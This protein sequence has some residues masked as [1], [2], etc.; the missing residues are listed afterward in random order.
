MKTKKRNIALYTLATLAILFAVYS[1]FQG[2]KL[3]KNLKEAQEKNTLLSNSFA[4]KNKL[5][6]I[7][8]ILIKGRYESALNA[9]QEEFNAVV[10]DDDK[11]YVKFRIE[12]AQQFIALTKGARRKDSL[13]DSLDL[14]ERNGKNEMLTSY[15]I[16]KYDSLT[17]ALEKAKVQLNRVK[18]QVQKKSYGEYLT[19]RNTKK[20]QLHY[21]GQVSEGKASGF[22]IA[23]FDTGSRYEGE[24]KD[25]LRHGE[26]AFYW[27]DGECYQG[28]YQ[29]DLRNGYGTYFWPNGEK[30]VG[31]WKNDQRDGEGVFYGKDEN[32]I[33][34]GV[35]KKD[36]LVDEYKDKKRK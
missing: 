5:F 17:F 21:I 25:N 36:K 31:N 13:A 34:K 29:N 7:D 16:R 24:W 18:K 15:N 10:N 19:F 33:T 14:L 32:I 8:S 23:L 11:T 9:Y 27:P 28:E 22:G 2:Q 35:W 6:K 30:Y 20:H 4:S 1:V 12:L 26:G 3:R